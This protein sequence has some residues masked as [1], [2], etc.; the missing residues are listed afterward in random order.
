M[1]YDRILFTEYQP[2]TT[3]R[4]VY[5]EDS[6]R[7]DAH[8]IGVVR[9]G[10]GFTLTSV[11]YVPDM[12]INLFSVAKALRRR[13]EITCSPAGCTIRRNE[14]DIMVATRCG[15]LFFIETRPALVNL[16]HGNVPT[17]N[18]TPPAITPPE[19]QAITRTPAA[20]ENNEIHSQTLRL[21]HQRLGHLNLADVRRLAGMAN[22]LLLAAAQGSAPPA[23]CPAC[24]G[25]K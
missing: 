12:E 17:S 4:P 8:G 19:S 3:T 2:L 16:A 5:L 23:V 24:I 10:N 21:W 14:R 7:V 6:T 1:C 9:L 11:L 25:R 18:S 15:N 22:G 13:Y 20:A